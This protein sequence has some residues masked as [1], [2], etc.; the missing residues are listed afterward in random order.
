MDRSIH[1]VVVQFKP[2]KGDYTANI[3]RLAGIFSQIDTLDPRPDVAVFAE[4]AL[5]GYFVEGGVRDVAMTAGALARDLQAQYAR[6]VTTP[7]PLDVCIG[8]YEVWNNAFYN[9]ALYVTLG[10]GSDEPVIRHV[11]RKL[12]LPTYGMFDEERFVDRGFE[13]RAFDTA[14]GRSAMLIC[15]DAWHSL[16]GTVA[17]L[18]GATTIFILSASP[19]RGVWPREDEGPVPA[20]LKRWERLARDIAEEQG[21]FVALVNLVGTEG[22][23][24]FSGGSIIAGPYGDV[25][26]KAPLWDETIMTITLDPQDLT[27]AR[28]DAPLLT[29]LQTMMPHLMRTVDRI[30]A[31]ERLVL[32]YDVGAADGGPL[33][34]LDRSATGER[35]DAP[36]SEETARRPSGNSGK[37]SGASTKAK[38]SGKSARASRNGSEP[39]PVLRMPDSPGGPPPVAIDAQLAAG[40][41]VSFLREEFERRGF[42]KA[43]VG[44][45]GG[46]DSAVTA[47]LSA[48]ALG[49]ENVIGV[50]MPYRTSNPDS[51]AHAQLV[52]DKL[53]IESRTID[54]SPA[55]D[56]YLANE[57]DADPGRRGNVMA[58][59]RMIVLFDLSA[60]YKALPVGTGNKTERL[61][62]Y[63]TWHADD[64]PPINPLGDLF[65]TQ[66]W[67]LATFLGVP[68]VIISKPA[69]AD[70]IEG[71][72]DERDFG[73]SY[74]EADEILNWLVS[75]YSPA[76]LVARGFD[77]A[78]VELVRKRLAGTHWKRKLPTVAMVSATGIGEAYLRPVDY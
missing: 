46:V 19:A 12:F 44:L 37:G 70:L 32:S 10:G 40:W 36:S 26:A 77:P 68:D 73:I 11:H 55:V 24:T 33:T 31:G 51:L 34:P 17:A 13:V 27:R 25:R 43:V 54:I 66:V 61:L 8:F 72:T 1:L 45:S 71:Q 52:I 20:N 7:R 75:G 3:E 35:A 64:S 53:G 65:K 67:Q 30:Q 78:K 57:P 76:S 41:L 2:R 63:F 48:Q 38:A 18:D 9:S 39:I 62:G 47:F 59:E 22:G 21:V 28:S 60:K 14:W 16:T 74:A 69:S 42:Q 6:A 23:K 49:P 50:R 15:E 56:G 58:R 29:D 5:T 4:T